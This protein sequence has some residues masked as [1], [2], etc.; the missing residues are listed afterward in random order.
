MPPAPIVLGMDFTEAGERAFD[1][2]LAMAKDLRTSLVVVHAFGGRYTP[3][4][5]SESAVAR[6]A[7]AEGAVDAATAHKLTTTYAERARREGVEVRTEARDGPPASVLLDV[8]SEV[9][10]SMI[11]VGSHS[12]SAIGRAI[13]GSVAMDVV[14]RSRR[15]VL[16]IPRPA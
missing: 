12:R 9:D 11:V 3:P 4:L 14:A 13:L 7:A 8:A 1:A 6:F 5:A 10:A 16:V 2:A 15:P